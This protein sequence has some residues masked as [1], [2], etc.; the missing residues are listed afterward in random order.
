MTADDMGRMLKRRM[1]DIHLPE[2]LSPHSFRV[3][4]TTD[5]LSQGVPLE[6]V[7]TLV[8]HADR[9]DDQALRSEAENR[10]EKRCREDF[11]VTR[12]CSLG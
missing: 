2:Q 9:Q 4:T 1:A 12:G 5:M 10:D 7:Q 8:G 6:D 11:G 3:G